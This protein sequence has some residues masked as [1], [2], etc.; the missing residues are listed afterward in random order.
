MPEL[1]VKMN[2]PHG[3]V[4][5]FRTALKV[6]V[7]RFAEEVEFAAARDVL[8][9]SKLTWE[10]AEKLALEAKRGIAKRHGVV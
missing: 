5:E 7:E 10:Q 4:P 6:V 2:V 3:M 1:V 8:A 9:K